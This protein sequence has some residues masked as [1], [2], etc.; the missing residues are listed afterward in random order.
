[1]R[2]EQAIYT[3]ARTSRTR[4][5]HLIAQS[6]GIDEHH[7]RSLI[8]WCPSHAGLASDETEASSINFHPVSSG[9]VALSRTVYGGPEYSS[10]GGLQIVT[11]VLLLRDEQLDGYDSDPIALAQVAMSLGHLRFDPSA[12]AQLPPVELPDRPLRAPSPQP[13]PSTYDIVQRVWQHLSSDK[14]VAVVNTTIPPLRTLAQL[15][16]QIARR[17]R[18][19]IA[20]TTGLKPSMNRPFHLH[21]LPSA[22][23]ML[24]RQLTGQGI[25]IVN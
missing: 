4:G 5:Y 10:R 7:A 24:Q 3:S 20:F 13:D 19:D 11:R 16:D 6:P 22:D 23:V 18:L 12:P 15:F 9:W 8:Q 2:A 17:H 14:R 25:A 1:M 21:F